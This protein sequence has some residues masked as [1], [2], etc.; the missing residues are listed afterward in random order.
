MGE[1]FNGIGALSLIISIIL[2]YCFRLKLLGI[3]DPLAIYLVTRASTMLSGVIYIV[4][5]IPLNLNIFILILSSSIFILILY[6]SCYNINIKKEICNKYITNNILIISNII[7]YIKLFILM[8]IYNEL[9]LWSYGGSDSYIN[10]DF[11]NKLASSIILGIGNMDLILLCFIAPIVNKKIKIYIF[12]LMAVS[13]FFA[14]VLGKKSSMLGVLTAIGIGEYLRIFFVCNQKKY[15]TRWPFI[16]SGISL[17][18]IWATWTFMKTSDYIIDYNIIKS[19]DD[20]IDSISFNWVYPYYIFANGELTN[21]FLSYRVHEVIYFMHSILSPLGF[22]AF[23]ASPGPAIHEY[24]YGNLTGNGINPT[25]IIEG[26][27]LFGV[28]L[29]FYSL[30]IGYIIAKTRNM[31][32]KIN[33][34]QTKVILSAFLIPVIPIIAID[35]LLFFKIIYI[36]IILYLFIILPLRFI[37]KEGK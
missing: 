19:L 10:F 15:F 8:S 12:L 29:P 37:L 2:I 3:L 27:I 24:L 7:F 9:P 20:V 25:F 32:F 34:L 11:D 16:V 33:S 6:K 1:N 17:S 23:V 13:V 31:I 5:I 22:P 35:S 4:F 21:F 30:L 14:L 26:Y 36:G 28:F 18:V